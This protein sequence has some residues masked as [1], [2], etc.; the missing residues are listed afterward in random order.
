VI[1]LVGAEFFKLRTT[2]TF[3]ALVGS[4]LGL[5]LLIVTLVTALAT[6]SAQDQPLEDMLSVT[7]FVQ[8]FALVLGILSVTTEYRHG[9]AT[10]SL[11][12]VP[13]RVAMTV[14]KLIASVITGLALGLIATVAVT[15]IVKGIGGARDI[16]TSGDAVNWIIG[17]TLATA[18]YAALGVGIG[19]IVRNQVGAIIGSL[20][21]LFV[22]ESLLT[23]I[24]GI[25]DVVTKYGIGGV[26]NAL[27]GV[28]GPDDVL[29][30]TAGGLLFALYAAVFV[31]V[32]IVVTQRRDVTA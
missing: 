17:G 8:A 16:D 19:A 29:G 13:N 28:Q 4:S 1:R 25:D 32:G 11:L 18:I 2:R 27:F 9:T 31:I 22:L 15:L 10:P 12:V 23:L 21:Y 20:V 26:S 5:V 30:Q 6:F 7:G 14:A 3:Y 24:P